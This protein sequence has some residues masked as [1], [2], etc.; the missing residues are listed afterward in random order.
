MS[1]YHGILVVVWCHLW[2]THG[3]KAQLSS[4]SSSCSCHLR[5]H[6]ISLWQHPQPSQGR[7]C[8][9]VIAVGLYWLQEASQAKNVCFYTHC[10]YIQTKRSGFSVT[11]ICDFNP[12]IFFRKLIKF[13][14][15]G[16]LS[17]ASTW[18][19]GN[20]QPATC[21]LCIYTFGTPSYLTCIGKSRK[22]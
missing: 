1:H 16:F 6:S 13:L 12:G 10:L 14:I 19:V 3:Y 9:K 15:W 22:F 20:I 18:P 7:N 4:L 2:A 21:A 11:E 5:W 8:H 17:A